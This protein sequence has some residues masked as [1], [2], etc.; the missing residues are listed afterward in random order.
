M[1]RRGHC[2]LGLVAA[3]SL[4][5]LL[6]G[7]H[8]HPAVKKLDDGLF[9]SSAALTEGDLG[10]AFYP[11]SRQESSITRQDKDGHGQKTVQLS[12]EAPL[13]TVYEWYRHALHAP[14]KT[15]VLAAGGRTPH[16]ALAKIHGPDRI[17]VSLFV[18]GG[19]TQVLLNRV[20]GATRPPSAA[21][22]KE[23]HHQRTTRP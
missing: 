11:G 5:L 19:R 2:I 23:Q 22:T 4:A 7:C 18:L 16:A 9:R 3:L 14:L 21:S 8:R 17:D 1:K 10:V 15:D 6:A 12:T 13:E 20:E